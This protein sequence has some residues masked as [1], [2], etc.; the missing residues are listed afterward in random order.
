[1]EKGK[2]I[3]INL[4]RLQKLSISVFMNNGIENKKIWTSPS[5]LEIHS[6]PASASDIHVRMNGFRSDEFLTL[7]AIIKLKTNL[8]MKNPTVSSICLPKAR[9][10]F[11]PKKRGKFLRPYCLISG[12]GYVTTGLET[13]NQGTL[14]GDLIMI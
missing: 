13:L 14:P 6:H 3:K 9:A 1:V 8:K 12:F 2:K 5:E 7:V 4:K 11:P 10:I